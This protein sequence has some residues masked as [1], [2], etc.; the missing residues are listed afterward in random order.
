M[1]DLSWL[2]ILKYNI[3]E[4]LHLFSLS[5]DEFRS[6]LW[7]EVCN[8]IPLAWKI[9]RNLRKRKSR[10]RP[11]IVVHH[12]SQ[13]QRVWQF[14]EILQ[15]RTFLKLGVSEE[16]QVLA[17]TC[18]KNYHHSLQGSINFFFSWW[19]V[20]TQIIIRH[21]NTVNK[22]I[23]W[24]LQ[25]HCKFRKVNEKL[26]KHWMVLCWVINISSCNVSRIIIMSL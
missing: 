2:L 10:L 17:V 16:K 13:L 18:L 20:S 15:P 23:E 12:P 22:V 14:W 3:E 7:H 24:S 8:A 11:F 26:I 9:L 19:W 6:M 21:F 4:N 1:H 25:N 5:R